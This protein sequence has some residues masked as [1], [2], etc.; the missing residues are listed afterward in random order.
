MLLWGLI[1]KGFFPVQDNGVLRALCRHR[2]PAP[3][4]ISPS[5]NAGRGRNLRIRQ[6]KA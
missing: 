6:C 3:L 2:N 1:P 4:P 5:D